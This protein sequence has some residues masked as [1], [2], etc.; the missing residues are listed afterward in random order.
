M[1]GVPKTVRFQT[2]WSLAISLL[3]GVL[4]DDLPRAPVHALFARLPCCPTCHA[5][6][7]T[8]WY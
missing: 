4:A 8:Q 3:D 6:L 5:S 2:K 7:M 1:A